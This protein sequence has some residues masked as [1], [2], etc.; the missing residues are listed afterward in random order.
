MKIHYYSNPHMKDYIKEFKKQK[1]RKNSLIVLSSL[2]FAFSLNAF[3]FYTP[4]W[5][6][7]QTSVKNYSNPKTDKVVTSDL[8]FK[9]SWTWSDIIELFS[10]NKMEKVTEIRF[11]VISDP[12][13]LKINDIFTDDKNIDV[14]KSSN[15]PWIS[16]VVLK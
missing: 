14:I 13:W 7:L 10:W 11:S 1:N 8:Y 4:V 5:N 2:V 6:K 16:M 9:K 3:M 12:A 15:V